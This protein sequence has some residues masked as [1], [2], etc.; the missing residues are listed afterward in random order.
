[1][2]F[3]RSRQDPA[4]RDTPRAQKDTFFKEGNKVNYYEK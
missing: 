3:E 4:K 2:L 1:M